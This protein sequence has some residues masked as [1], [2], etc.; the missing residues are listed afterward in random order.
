MRRNERTL[1]LSRFVFPSVAVLLALGFGWPT[2]AVT[3]IDNTDKYA[4]G[5]SV[6]WN[7]LNN[8]PN[9]KV[10]TSLFNEIGDWAL[11]P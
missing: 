10:K 6:G 8:D 5:A 4:Y 9:A 11:Y 3:T 1:P 2:F 7:S